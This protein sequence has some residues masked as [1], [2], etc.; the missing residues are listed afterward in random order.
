[1][2]T[3]AALALVLVALLASPV[4]AV[5]VKID[6]FPIPTAAS[7]PRSIAVGADGNLWFTELFGNNIGRITRSGVVTEFPVRTSFGG[8]ST[9]TAGPD[10]ALWFTENN[11]GKIGRITTAGEVTEFS[12]SMLSGPDGITAGPDGALWFTEEGGNKIG[13]ITPLG[14]V[15]GF[16]IPTLNGGP[17]GITVGPDGNLWFTETTGNQIGRSTLGGQIDEFPL[18]A[19]SN[20]LFGIAAGP[21]GNL[22]FVEEGGNN[23]GRLAVLPETVS[24]P[25]PTLGSLS[26]SSATAGAAAFTLA[27]KGGNFMPSSVVQWN[28]AARVTTFVSGAELHAAISTVDVAGAGTSQ[29][30]VVTPAPGGGS[31]TAMTFAI[32]GP[33]LQE[34]HGRGQYRHGDGRHGE[35]EDRDDHRPADKRGHGERSTEE[36]DRDDS[37]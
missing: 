20:P 11:A 5:T 3:G 30:T 37:D 17:R 13:R 24:N 6:E 12:L 21:D 19:T 18:T 23:I 16:P 9:V 4:V 7:S 35:R 27:V 36:S 34:R 8:P 32:Q 29:V 31:S 26:P 1:M 15:T 33:V 25:A 22:W 2:R 14:V 28:G 10:G